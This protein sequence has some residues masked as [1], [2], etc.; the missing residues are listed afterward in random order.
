MKE[1][2]IESQH[3]ELKESLSDIDAINRAIVAFANNG[4]GILYIGIKDNS[5]ITGVD[6][7]K[8]TLENLAKTIT[9]TTEPPI[10]PKIKI[11]QTDDK[12]IILIE[13][14][15]SKSK[16]H[17]YK[18]I[19]YKRVGKTNIQMDISEIKEMIL[20][21]NML[22]FEE[23]LTD[24]NLATD[25]DET[26]FDIFL[27]QCKKSNRV[28]ISEIERTTDIVKKLDAEKDGRIKLGFT[29]LFA[30]NPTTYLPHF[31]IR[32]A[33]INTEYFSI[34]SLEKTKMYTGSI[35][36]ILEDLYFDVLE[37]LPKKIYLDGLNRVEEP[38]VP[39]K[40]IRELILNAIIHSDYKIASKISILIT[41]NYIEISNPGALLEIKIS[42]L[43]KK[44]KSILR[45]PMMANIMFLSGNIEQW[46]SGIENAIREVVRSGLG[47]PEFKT[48]G[49]FFNVRVNFSDHAKTK[50]ALIITALKNS[51]KS[52]KE[53]GKAIN[54][55]DRTVRK[56]LRRLVNLGMIKQIRKGKRIN[57][58]LA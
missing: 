14:N 51:E 34:E 25:I 39:K 40:A 24:F 37:S 4:G 5:A 22:S 47:V 10:L 36:K 17:F 42:D 12:A 30:K 23:E 1:K 54:L 52:S 21:Q 9:K 46:A 18:K 6:L 8:N 28:K 31:G 58:S 20:K 35:F 27:R 19:A 44:H 3:V 55:A 38:I 11:E 26:A 32:F 48:E 45:N 33:R 43:Y 49:N 29:L 57:Y 2:L 41:P 53:I 7:G 13:V 15:E 16:P 56:E 50:D